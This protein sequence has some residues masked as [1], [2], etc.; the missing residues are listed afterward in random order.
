S[1][2]EAAPAPPQQWRRNPATAH[3]TAPRFSGRRARVEHFAHRT[4]EFSQKRWAHFPGSSARERPVRSVVDM[5]SRR[6]AYPIYDG[7]DGQGEGECAPNSN[8]T[9]DYE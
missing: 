7:A 6:N 3:R 9:L 5:H 2:K 8:D 4:D 1:I